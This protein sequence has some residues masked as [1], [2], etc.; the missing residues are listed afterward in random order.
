MTD[1]AGE[2]GQEPATPAGKRYA[3]GERARLVRT[4]AAGAPG[5]RLSAGRRL[6][7]ALGKP[8]FEAL[9]R[10]WWASCRWRVVAGDEHM[11]AAIAAGTPVIPCYWH[12]QSLFGAR[13]MLE[14]QRR[15]MNV[16]FLISPSVDGEVP[17]S[18]VKHMGASVIRGSSTRTGAQALRDMYLAVSRN[19]TSLVA[20]ADGPR[21]PARVFKAGAV[22]LAKLTGAPMIPM[23]C[24]ARSAWYLKRW[25]RFQ[26]PKPFSRVAIAVGAPIYVDKRAD[27][28]A[29]Q[30]AQRA[31]ESA[32]SALET[33]AAET[34]AAA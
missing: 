2:P 21:G 27:E 26:I 13:Y 29:V 30:A 16:G 32:I 23:A 9:V 34:L 4:R 17:A 15:G 20:T 14:Q 5:R 24:A 31:M 3:P 12:Q 22:N 28:P 1:S 8:V 33:V 6:Y 18:I 7:Y 19:K 10:L 11:T 25:D